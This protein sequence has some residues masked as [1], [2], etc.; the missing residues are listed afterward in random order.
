MKKRIPTLDE[1]VNEYIAHPL[2]FMNSDDYEFEGDKSSS[3]AHKEWE[4]LLKIIKDPKHRDDVIDISYSEWLVS[5]E[6]DTDLTFIPKNLLN[7]LKKR[8]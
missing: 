1:F 4:E 8:N 7:K 6:E 5:F 2:S 3:A